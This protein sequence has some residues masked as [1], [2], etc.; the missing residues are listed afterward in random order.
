[1]RLVRYLNKILWLCK[2]IIAIQNLGILENGTYDFVL[3]SFLSYF[4]PPQW[5]SIVSFCYTISDRRYCFQSMNPALGLQVKIVKGLAGSAISF[6]LLISNYEQFAHC[7]EY[8]KRFCTTPRWREITF[9]V[10]AVWTVSLVYS[11][12]L[13]ICINLHTF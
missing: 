12:F 8:N 4:L 11:D 2:A 1:M 6:L 9:I 3:P 7:Y 10:V 5:Y 13:A